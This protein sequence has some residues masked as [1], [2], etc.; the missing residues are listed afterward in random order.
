MAG[1]REERAFWA[2]QLHANLLNAIGAAIMQSQVC[3]QAIRAALPTSV[4]EVLRLRQI[5]HALEDA[6]RAMASAA[7][8]VRRDVVQDV[9][10]RTEAF[11]AAHPD[12]AV[13]LTVHGRGAAVPRRI[14]AGTGIVLAE[15]LRNAAAH[16]R[17]GAIDVVLSVAHGS[18]LLRVRDDGC[19]FDP[20]AIGDAA[21]APDGRPRLGLA[22]MREWAQALGGR[23]ALSSVPGRGTQISLHVPLQGSGSVRVEHSDAHAGPP[24]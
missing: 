8:S 7:S 22:I 17:A 15:A 13:R 10:M 4:D 19:G 24:R 2:H 16:G 12:V 23:L 9:R 1:V 6:T 21:V 3:E 18:L 20:R 5:L 14:V 11:A